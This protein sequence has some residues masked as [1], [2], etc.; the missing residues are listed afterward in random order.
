W[1]V[2]DLLG[3]LVNKSLAQEQEEAGGEA[4][5]NLLETV[6]QYGAEKLEASGETGTL[7]ERHLA[8]ILAL[9]EQAESALRG[10]EQGVWL[11]RL[12]RE[13]DN[14]RVAL[15]WAR[16]QGLAERGLQLAGAL[17]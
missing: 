3:S 5:Y 6:R 2:L 16:E 17:W 12:E 15:V 7:R 14:L 9:A 4:R 13:H 11:E 10:P 1:Q 8:W